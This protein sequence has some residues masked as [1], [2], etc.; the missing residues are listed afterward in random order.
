[1]TVAGHAAALQTLEEGFMS[2][3]ATP[4]IDFAQRGEPVHEPVDI[5]VLESDHDVDTGLYILP[6]QRVVLSATGEIW[7]GVWLTGRNGPQ[8]WLGWH[9]NQDSPLPYSPPFSMLGRLDGRYFYVGSGKEFIY[10]SGT[11]GSKL[12]L[13]INDDIPGNGSGAF[14]L[15][16]EVYAS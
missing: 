9:A 4:T 7:A 12:F 11:D 6:G 13:R 3:T 15:H 16:V 10:R 2:D 8:G 14:T 1:M 5:T